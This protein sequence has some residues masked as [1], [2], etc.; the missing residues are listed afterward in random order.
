M[1]KIFAIAVTIFFCLQQVCSQS[2][3]FEI[4]EWTISNT[5]KPLLF[6]ISGDGGFNSFSTELCE[7]LHRLGYYVI[8]LNAK[9]YFWD[10]KTP[11]QTVAD[12]EKCMVQKMASHQN[13]KIQFIGYSFGADV[14]PFLLTRFSAGMKQHICSAVMLASSGSTDFEIHWTDIFGTNRKR[15]MDVVSEINKISGIKL[16]HISS[17]E[18]DLDESKI[19]LPGYIHQ[20][21]PGG[22]HFDGD[23]N[24]LAKRIA[25]FAY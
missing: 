10:K 22:H 14:L 7:H 8:A 11:E 12:I 23:V 21:L 9:S 17:D 6:Y 15:S 4:K 13:K 20:Q 5:D 19:K 25:S 16:I 2:A 24:E 1:K 3:D 18:D